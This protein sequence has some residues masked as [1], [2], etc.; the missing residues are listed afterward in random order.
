MNDARIP[1]R[2]PR[3]AVSLLVAVFAAV[4]LAQSGLARAQAAGGLAAGEQ[5]IAAFLAEGGTLADLCDPGEPHGSGAVQCDLCCLLVVAP[6]P[7]A[8]LTVVALWRLAGP[9]GLPPRRTDTPVAWLP[10]GPPVRAPPA[11]AV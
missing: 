6:L 8:P 4:A 7:A 10:C 3:R 9:R 1:R 2:L 5:Q 11:H